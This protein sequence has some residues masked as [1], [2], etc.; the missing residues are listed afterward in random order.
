MV[1]GKLQTG[2]GVWS[3]MEPRS[4]GGIFSFFH[5]LIMVPAVV[6]T[7]L[8]VYGPVAHPRPR[9]GLGFGPWDSILVLPTV[10]RWE[11]VTGVFYT[12]KKLKRVHTGD[13]ILISCDGREMNY[14]IVFVFIK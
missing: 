1:F 8:L 5:F 3:C 11:C 14:L 7:K 6:L 9:A 12:G 13:E 2:L 10:E 4:E